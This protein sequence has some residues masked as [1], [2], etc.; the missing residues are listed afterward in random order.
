MTLKK[1]LALADDAGLYVNVSPL[2]KSC[3][4]L[5]GSDVRWPGRGMESGHFLAGV[6]W[7]LYPALPCSPALGRPSRSRSCAAVCELPPSLAPQAAPLCKGQHIPLGPCMQVHTT[8]YP[9][10]AIRGQIMKGEAAA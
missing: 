6:S 2:P 3:V 9:G 8:E 4:P 7:S 5:V 1:L 10:G